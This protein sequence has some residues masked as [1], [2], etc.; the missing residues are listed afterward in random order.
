MAVLKTA[1]IIQEADAAGYSRCA[2]KAPPG[3]QVIQ[4][5]DDIAAGHMASFGDFIQ[6]GR[7]AVLGHKGADK[8]QHTPRIF[9]A[10]FL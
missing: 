9:L 10:V 7:M 4:V 6:A 1:F 3:F 2:S 5:T 8:R